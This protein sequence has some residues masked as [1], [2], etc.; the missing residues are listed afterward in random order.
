[1]SVLFDRALRHEVLRE[2][3]LLPLPPSWKNLLQRRL[4][5]GEVESWQSRLQGPSSAP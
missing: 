5:K 2:A 3:S 4:E 1:M